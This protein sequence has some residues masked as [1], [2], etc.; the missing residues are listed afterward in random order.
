VLRG[1]II[2]LFEMIYWPFIS[3]HLAQDLDDE[4]TQGILPLAGENIKRLA[5]KALDYH[6]LRLTV[7]KSGYRHRHHG[8]L[9]MI[10]SCSRSALVLVAAVLHN[11]ANTARNSARGAHI[12]KLPNGWQTNL[13]ETI[14]MLEFW[15]NE[16]RQS[17]GIRRVLQAAREK[18]P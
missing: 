4:E 15:E 12:L 18:V 5:Q 11:I 7:N 17:A 16:S 2:N 10:Q 13:D 8:T 1:H 6:A 3:A 14:D 9:L